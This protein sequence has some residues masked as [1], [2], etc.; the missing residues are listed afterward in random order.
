M[1]ENRFS[2]PHAGWLAQKNAFFAGGHT[3]ETIDETCILKIKDSDEGIEFAFLMNNLGLVEQ[4]LE[5]VFAAM[6]EAPKNRE[7]YWLFCY[8]CCSLLSMFYKGYAQPQKAEEFDKLKERLRQAAARGSYRD[9]PVEHEK[10]L[11][12]VV[13]K[14]SEAAR[15]ILQLP[16]HLS[17]MRDAVSFA[18]L[19]R[20]YWLFCRLSLN[21]AL[22]LVK[23][24]GWVDKIDK[25][26]G[27][28]TNVDKAIRVLNT[29]NMVMSALG[30]GFFGI[31][32]MLNFISSMKH[33][34]FPTAAEETVPWH[35]RAHWEWCKRDL[36][37]FN[38]MTWGTVNGVTNYVKMSLATNLCVTAAFLVFD[39]G[40]LMYSHHRARV[41]YTQKLAQYLDEIEETKNSLRAQGLA[42]AEYQRLRT[43]LNMLHEQ[44]ER[45][46]LRW[47]VQC[48]ALLF[49]GTAA[50]LLA[51]GFTC[52]IIFS[53][54]L[55]AV[56]CYFVCIVGMALYLSADEFQKY[57]QCKLELERAEHRG[58][59]TT[60][61]KAAY[62]EAR[63]EFAFTMVKNI[64]VPSLI[65]ATFVVCW[66]A[67]IVLTVL[68]AGFELW[69]AWKKHQA[70]Q[71]AA[72]APQED[73][74]LENGSGLVP[75]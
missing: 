23:K 21:N 8:F 11:D 45:L 33:T 43:H 34:F 51:A 49:K 73:H 6:R 63:R 40:L 17:K 28:H 35:A 44:M 69:N 50:T 60:A 54:P 66:Q 12:Y 68:Y 16:F 47:N 71:Q 42:A 24:F 5:D 38:D 10:F 61:A 29:P 70:L 1:P 55:A 26:F 41:A 9:K 39:I 57:R 59:D 13:R 53:G 52:S 48:T 58:L 2:S 30:V 74:E 64:I 72:D 19:L 32:L 14:I 7:Q 22:S 36:V 27:N 18:N 62:L 46:N 56:G 20:I 31:R 67:A 75:A 25:V 3:F 65:I 15:A 4:E 37:N